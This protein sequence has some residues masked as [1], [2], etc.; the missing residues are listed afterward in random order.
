MKYKKQWMFYFAYVW[1][2]KIT[3]FM[4]VAS[5]QCHH[6]KYGDACV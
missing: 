5:Q 6:G 3:V 4:K 1:D 2:G